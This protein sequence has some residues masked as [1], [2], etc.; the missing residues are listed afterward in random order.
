MMQHPQ[1]RGGCSNSNGKAKKK[2]SP[3]IQLA[4]VQNF[5]YSGSLAFKITSSSFGVLLQAWI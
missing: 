1:D 5:N 4:S 3:G 2:K